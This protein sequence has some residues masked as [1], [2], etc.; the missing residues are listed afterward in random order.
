MEKSYTKILETIRLVAKLDADNSSTVDVIDL[1]EMV[2]R[3]G[4][5]ENVVQKFIDEHNYK[6]RNDASS[7]KVWS[8]WIF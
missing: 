7:V 6:Q 4:I 1:M 3:F 2:G 8:L 5:N